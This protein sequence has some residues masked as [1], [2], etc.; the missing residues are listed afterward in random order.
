MARYTKAVC[1]L[2]RREGIKLNLKGERCVSAK[3]AIERR[4][5]PPGQQM[6]TR[7]RKRSNYATQLR[8]KQKAKRFYGVLEKQ[9]RRYYAIAASYRG[10][11]GTLLMQ[12]LERRLD[13][14]V[15]R[16]GF[17]PS[18]KSARQLVSHGHITVNGRKLD[19]PSYLCKVNDEIV[20]RERV[21]ESL[22]LR[23]AKEKLEK[24]AHNV[25]EWLEVNPESLTGKFLAIPSQED[26]DAP[27]NAQLIVEL[28]SK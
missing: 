24:Q 20:V 8:E 11:T 1:R 26:V 18:R 6:Q 27:V 14:L 21:R 10:V 22:P 28:Y 3:C 17:A 5:S 4:K 7:R 2:C 19:A 9:F 25:P 16:M 12:L 23:I 15:Y 13:N